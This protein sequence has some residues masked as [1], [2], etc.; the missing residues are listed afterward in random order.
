MTFLAHLNRDKLARDTYLSLNIPQRL[1]YL[2]RWNEANK[3]QLRK[4]VKK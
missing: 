3:K 1:N 4:K 2:K